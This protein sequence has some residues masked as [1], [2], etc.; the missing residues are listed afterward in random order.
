MTVRYK[1]AILKVTKKKFK[2][3]MKLK[4]IVKAGDKYQCEDKK[5]E[6]FSG[7]SGSSL[8]K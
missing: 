4:Q 7:K 8:G 2:V 6:K 1:F 3:V 5:I